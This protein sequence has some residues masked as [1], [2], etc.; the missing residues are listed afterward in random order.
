P[1]GAAAEQEPPG[2]RAEKNTQHEPENVDR[3]GGVEADAKTAENADEAGDGHGIGQGD[4]DG[5]EE[6]GGEIA[7]V[8]GA[9]LARGR[10]AAHGGDADKKQAE[11][12]EELEGD[13]V[14]IEEGRDGG[15]ADRGDEAEN[16]VGG[17]G[18]ETGDEAGETAIENGAADAEQADRTHRRGDGETNGEALDQVFHRRVARI[19]PSAPL[20]LRASM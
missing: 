19:R 11:A 6:G 16:P 10:T 9:V 4:G 13:F 2:G 14:V 7:G 5:R 8:H 15:E 20:Q 17:G 18:A 1:A 12:A 3:P